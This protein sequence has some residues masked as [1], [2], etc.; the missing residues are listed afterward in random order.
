MKNVYVNVNFEKKKSGSFSYP[1]DHSTQTL[2][3]QLKNCDQQLAYRDTDTHRQTDRQTDT[4]VTTVGT[5]SEF[6]E[7]F[8]QSIIKDRLNNKHNAEL[9]Q[10]LRGYIRW[11]QDKLCARFPK[12]PKVP[13][14]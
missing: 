14:S 11:I 6:K 7:F 13:V 10:K 3:S 4:K 5:L 2:D 9:Q 12:P 8:F 1:K